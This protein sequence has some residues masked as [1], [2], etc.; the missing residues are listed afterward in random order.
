MM[1][2]TMIEQDFT[3]QRQILAADGQRPIYHFLPPANWINDPHGLIHWKGQYHL[4]YQYNPNGP[5]H[6]TIHWGHAVSEDFIHWRDLPIALAP[7]TGP[8]AYDSDGC[9]TGSTV[10]DNGLPTIY[11]TAAY[12]QTIAAAVSYDELITWQKLPENPVIEGP[13]PDI[14]PFS[15]G[16]FRDPMVWKTEEGWEMLVVTKIEGQGGQVLLYFSPDLRN[17]EYRGIF[18]AGNTHITEPFWQ[19]TMW[20]CPNWLNFGERQALLVSIQSTP[21]DHLYS[22]YFTGRREENIFM[23]AYSDMLVHG[24]SFYA[25][26][27][28][29]L[30]DNRY[31][32]LGWLHEERSN[33]ACQQSGWSG[34]LSLPMI[35]EERENGGLAVNP[36]PELESL[37]GELRHINSLHL[38]DETES[39]VFDISGKALEIEATFEFHGDSEFGLKVFCSPG[40]EEYTTILYKREFGQI[41]IDRQHS[42]VDQRANVNAA[43]IPVRLSRGEPIKLHVFI[44]HSIVEVFLNDTFC[45]A[46]RVYPTREDSDGVRFFSHR[47]LV[48]AKD[49][50]IWKMNPIW[51]AE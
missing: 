10:D 24:G 16:N 37:R 35:I 3:A 14:R 29:R 31:L 50:N 47:G 26:Q 27:A 48:E 44:D 36:M 41:Q 28:M 34:S 8:D 21:E 22:V 7:G 39:R 9:W 17:W 32:M 23:P 12:P 13:P 45:L 49:I 42:S 19:G 5:F 38:L 30:N 18:L 46:C 33:Q 6:G 20:E 25:P 15:G 40:N 4:F 11:Y 51:P 1:D 43:T 2:E